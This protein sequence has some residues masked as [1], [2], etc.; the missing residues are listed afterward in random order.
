MDILGITL[1]T[2]VILL[3]LGSL[4]AIVRGRLYWAGGDVREGAWWGAF[5]TFSIGG[6]MK[7][8][9]DEQLPAGAYAAVEVRNVAGSIDISGSSAGAVTVHSTRMA[10]TQAAMDR[11]HV[12]VRR[13]GDRLVLE[14]KHDPGFIG[15][16]GTVAFRVTVPS[17]VKVIEA[18][19]VSGSVNVTGVSPAVDQT[20]STIS[21]SVETAAAHNLDI[22]STSG[23]VGFVT[24]GSSLNARTVSGSID[25]TIDSLASNGTARVSSVSGSVSLNAFAGLDA[26]L[27][28]HSVSGSVS[29]DFPVTIS[30]QKRNSIK[31][32]VGNGSANLDVGTVSGSISINRK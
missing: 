29:C 16:T 24:T 15:N 4:I 13:D 2:I 22:S 28:L 27:S 11:L 21:G 9:N 18:H 30:E 20:L 8:E 23:H 6:S 3:V 25:G 26:A 31:G 17:G 12:E 5:P 14:E 19:S 32:R 1:G 10:P 7:V